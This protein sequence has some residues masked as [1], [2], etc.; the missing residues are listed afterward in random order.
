MK[1]AITG[2]TGFIGQALLRI[3]L[4]QGHTVSALARHPNALLKYASASLDTIPGDLQNTTALC[5]LVSDVDVV[6]HLAGVVRGRNQTAFDAINVAG[7]RALLAALDRRPTPFI[8]CS[9]LAA[10]EPQ[11]S[12]YARSKAAAESLV[13]AEQSRRPTMILRPC[14]VYGPGDTE[15]M[16]VFRFMRLSG[17]APVP[18]RTSARLSLIYVD[19]VCRAISSLLDH[20]D[21]ASGTY[22]IHDGRVGGYDWQD[23]AQLVGAACGKRIKP[24]A[25]PA[26]ILDSLAFINEKTTMVTRTAP[27]LTRAKLREL[28]HPDWVVT[29]HER[30]TDACGWSPRTRLAEGLLSTAE[31]MA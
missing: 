7:T 25:I 22:E 16:P 27:M 3:L 4:E 13:L 30:L 11:L 19:D 15:M 31:W 12:F 1:V 21:R 29:T 18:G 17:W 10:R 23:L 2:A 5:K 8:L 14:A 9:S 20:T 26:P 6:I 28:R 24:V